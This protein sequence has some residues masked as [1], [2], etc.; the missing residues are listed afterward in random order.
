MACQEFITQLGRNFQVIY[1]QANQ[2][3]QKVQAAGQNMA[4]TDSAVGSSWA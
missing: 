4:Q 2:H 3:G 1:E